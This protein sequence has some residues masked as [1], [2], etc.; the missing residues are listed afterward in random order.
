M[1]CRTGWLPSKPSATVE[2]RKWMAERR[3]AGPN[4]LGGGGWAVTVGRITQQNHCGLCLKDLCHHTPVN[5]GALMTNDSILVCRLLLPH[6]QKHFQ[7][8]IIR[9]KFDWCTISLNHRKVDPQKYSKL[10]EYDVKF[11]NDF[12]FVCF[13]PV[14][15]PLESMEVLVMR[16]GNSRSRTDWSVNATHEQGRRLSG[17][18]A[19][20]E[21]WRVV[22][23]DCCQCANVKFW[24]IYTNHDVGLPPS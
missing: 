18:L 1:V 21:G 17:L 5:S 24:M 16:G 8:R 9:Q 13:E 19:A 22:G 12:W 6:Q 15:T 23:N 7:R 2:R 14:Q 20:G 10:A 4:R 11:N 3:E